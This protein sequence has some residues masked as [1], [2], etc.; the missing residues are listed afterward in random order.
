VLTLRWSN[1]ALE[2]AAYGFTFWYISEL[3]SRAFAGNPPTGWKNMNVKEMGMNAVK[4]SLYAALMRF[5]PGSAVEQKAI[6]LYNSYAFGYSLGMNF[7]T[8]PGRRAMLFFEDLV[9]ILDKGYSLLKDEHGTPKA[10]RF[11]QGYKPW[12]DVFKPNSNDA[13]SKKIRR[14]N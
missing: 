5:A 12:A 4:S 2:E 9:E 1:R 10:K 11:I 6:A 8:E 13:T 7:R 3:G 14:T